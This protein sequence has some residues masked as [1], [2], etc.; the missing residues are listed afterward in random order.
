MQLDQFADIIAN[1]RAEDWSDLR[2]LLSERGY[3][4]LLSYRPD[5]SITLGWGPLEEETFEEPWVHVF[6]GRE[7]FPYLLDW[8]WF[9]TPV[10]RQAMV[11][12][13]NGRCMLPRPIIGASG[14]YEVPSRALRIARLLHDILGSLED[15]DQYL[16]RA[17][18]QVVE[19]P[20]P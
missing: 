2:G 11:S 16:K 18:F 5:L 4:G 10:W 7:A 15:F 14:E 13:D 6:S 3:L 20:W 9:G 12:V 19:D 1:S 8:L 17:G